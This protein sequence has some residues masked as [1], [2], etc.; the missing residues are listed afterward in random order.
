MTNLLEFAI[1]CKDDGSY[2]FVDE[3]KKKKMSSIHNVKFFSN[4]T[5]E[6]SYWLNF[7]KREFLKE[8]LINC[9]TEFRHIS[10][11]LIF[12]IIESNI[13]YGKK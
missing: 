12:N 1:L 9:S 2:E 11:N 6:N 13:F 10:T 8:F 3:R 7:F 5:K 4:S